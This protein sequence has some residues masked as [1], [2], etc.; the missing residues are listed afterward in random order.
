MIRLRLVDESPRLLSNP[1]HAAMQMSR[2]KNLRF[3]HGGSLHYTP[4]QRMVTGGLY[5]SPD[6]GGYTLGVH[7]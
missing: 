6:H 3:T 7:L 4:A 2:G 5:S 1:S